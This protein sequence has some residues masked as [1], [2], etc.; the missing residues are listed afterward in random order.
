MANPTCTIASLNIACFGG[1]VLDPLK[2]KMLL[3]YFKAAELKGIGG[4]NY[5]N[6]LTGASPGGLLYDTEQLFNEYVNKDKIGYCRHVGLFEL[7]IARNNAIASGGDVDV[8][9][10]TRM[11][12]IK[13]L[14]NVNEDMLDRMCLCLECQLGVHKTYPQ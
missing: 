11:Q 13:C 9:I 2:R 4:T 8:T 7:S 5:L 12:Q 1:H 10:Q 6:T 14:L 3:V